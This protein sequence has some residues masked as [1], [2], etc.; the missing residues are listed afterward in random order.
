MTD[1][2]ETILVV[3]YGGQY[4]HLIARRLRSMGVYSE[5]VEPGLS[6]EGLNARSEEWRVKGIILSGGPSS[7]HSPTSPRATPLWF[8]GPILGLCYG[9]QLLAYEAGGD[10]VSSES[11]E[12]GSTEATLRS[13]HR[14]F[15]GLEGS[16]RVWMSH[17][18]TVKQLPDDLEV[19]AS[20]ESCPV[21]AFRH[22]EKPWFGLQWHPE[23][24]H[25]EGGETVLRNFAFDICG[26]EA[27]WSPG[28]MVDKV[29]KE[30]AEEIGDRRALIAVSGGL[31][32]S[33]AALIAHRA[34]GDRLQ[35]VF[36]DHGLLRSDEAEQVISTLRRIGV[37]FV[38]REEEERFL[39]R[40]RGI[41]D[42]EEKRRVVGEEFVRVF[43]EVGEETD[44]SCL[45][46]GT[47][48]SD[49]VESGSG[50]LAD[51]IKSHH[52]VG[53]LP[54]ETSF[55]DIVEPLRDFY[56]DEVAEI[57]RRLGVP[58]EIL[59]RQPFPGPGLAVRIIGEVTPGKVEVAREADAIVRKEVERAD[60][61]R[62]V[63]QFF[64]VLTDVKTTGVKGDQRAY[65]D[66]VAVRVVESEE[67]MTASF[68]KLPYGVLESIST[69]IANSI[70]EVTR[71]VYDI[72]HKPPATIE[73]E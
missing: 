53:G 64:A 26:C 66:T 40:L 49:W 68:A 10:V 37:N 72:T 58:S 23:V 73:W 71:V 34:V 56:K 17:G 46:Q 65:G 52:N 48:Y 9:H 7:V 27:T 41:R 6:K 67:A 12:Y 11:L 8:D 59:E 61:S 39:S 29:V 15:K 54:D 18:D 16:L 33:T 1:R 25:T 45:V 42:P 24:T 35:A 51:R 28:D 2:R 69:R 57:G 36:V 30:T 62:N 60:L 43:E 4:S 31:D 3:D 38:V 13:N 44:C 63:W 32:S 21:A 70:P 55:E 19:L 14:L 47:V 20:T 22:T 50:R 5:I